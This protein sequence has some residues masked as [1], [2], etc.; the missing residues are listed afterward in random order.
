MKETIER[1]WSMNRAEWVMAILT[2]I[3]IV[4]A[5]LT[6]AIFW[7][8]LSAMKTD[9][10]AW[11]TLT[12]PTASPEPEKQVA[13]DGATITGY[14]I[15]IPITVTNA[16]KTPARHYSV[17][18]AVEKVRVDRPPTLSYVGPITRSVSGILFPNSPFV[19]E[20]GLFDANSNAPDA[21]NGTAK[22][23]LSPAEFQRLRDG[24]DYMVLYA[25]GSYVD[26]FGTQHW[27]HYCIV[28]SYRVPVTVP[29][30]N[31]TEYNDVDDN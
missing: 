25:N 23:T 5:C 28:W 3:G 2:L 22:K 1:F 4:V 10:R 20:T 15:G 6:G 8:Q 30:R 7:Q 9:Q 26:I 16:G 31:C 17:D 14:T 11:V 13:A 21:V 27:H 18:I 19:I 12:A 24:K 29:S